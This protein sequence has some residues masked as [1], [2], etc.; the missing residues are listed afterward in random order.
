MK[1]LPYPTEEAA[2]PSRREFLLAGGAVVTTLSLGQA[3]ARGRT[4]TS[5]EG[6]K[7]REIMRRYGSELGHAR[8]RGQE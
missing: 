8:Y 3:R 2:G 1:R 4:R 5:E 7:I 6:E